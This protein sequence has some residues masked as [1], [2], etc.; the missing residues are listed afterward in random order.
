MYKL[1]SGVPCAS[2][3]EEKGIEDIT[4]NKTEAL[5]PEWVEYLKGK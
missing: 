3:P 1:V 5:N 2:D 4:E